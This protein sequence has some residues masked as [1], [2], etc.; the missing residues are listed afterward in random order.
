MRAR[1]NLADN[2]IRASFGLATLAILLFG[3]ALFDI[4]EKALRDQAMVQDS[5]QVL[6]KIS[7]L[8]E[9][10]ALA[11]S[12]HRGLLLTGDA[13]FREARDTALSHLKQHATAIQD[14]AASDPIQLARSQRLVTLID[15]RIAIMQNTERLRTS[16]G[17]AAAIRAFAG[18]L[19]EQANGQI[20]DLVIE[21]AEQET[22]LL[23]ARQKRE[24]EGQAT[25]RRIL[26][27]AG[28]ALVAILLPLMW[29][30][31][32]QSRDRQKAELRLRA[33]AHSLP[34][35]VYVFR[36]TPTGVGAFEFVSINAK[37]VLGIAREQVLGDPDTVR[38]LVFEEDHERITAAIVRSAGELSA[39]EVDFR[40]RKGADAF[41][42]LRSSAIPVRQADGDV[43]WHGYWFDITDT[44]DAEQALQHA[45]QRL[46]DAH[47]VA[48][49][50]DWTCDLATGAVT[51][52]SH[53][54]DML[55]RDPALG[56]LNLEEAVAIFENGAEATAD[57]FFK[58]Q[59]SGQSQAYEMK[60]RLPAGG[61]SAVHVI[62]VPTLDQTGAV[63]GMHGTIQDITVRKALE[64][65]LSLA[66]E[67]ADVANRAKSEFLA[68]MSHEIRTPLTGMLGLLEL[69]GLMPLS[70]DLRTA[71]EGVRESG[72]ALQRIIDDILDFS[73]VEAGKLEIRPEP[74]SIDEIVS[75][76]NRVYGGLAK[77]RGLEFR[78]HLD[79]RVSRSV[80]VDGLRLR[81]IL[82]NFLSNAIKFTPSGHVELRVELAERTGDLESLRFHVEDTGIGISPERQER[83]F[84]PFEQAEEDIAKRVGGT[85]L[86]LSI[87]RR[88]A[89]LMGG[90]VSIS[91]ELGKGTIL[92]LDL[93]VTVSALVPEPLMHTEEVVPGTSLPP[94]AYAAA[95]PAAGQ[96][97]EG[98]LVLVV[99]DHPINRML[100]ARQLNT[101]G[102][103]AEEVES[104]AEA[105]EQWSTGRFALVLT[106]C[107]MPEMSGYDLSRRIREME[108]ARGGGR[109]PIIACSANAIRG[110]RQDCLDAGMDEYVSKP[111]SLATLSEALGHWLP[112]PEPRVDAQAGVESPQDVQLPAGSAP[113]A[114]PSPHGLPKGGGAANRRVAEHFRRINDVDVQRLMQAIEQRDMATI[115]HLAH[116]IKGACGFIGASNLASISA[117]VEQAGRSEDGPAIDWLIDIFQ[118]EL[119]RLNAH[120][121]AA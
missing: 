73:K 34:G 18:R 75:S 35:A 104:G 82:S 23:A 26:M 1:A 77:S 3:W 62:V 44:K 21:L 87:C 93:T 80:M 60:T 15:K 119:E 76:V 102:Y 14:A 89:E 5:E 52:S 27:S 39:L 94:P 69:I 78:Q 115:A 98:P 33:I 70:A 64:E 108:S 107:H 20:N 12:D 63:I 114:G 72:I 13:Q 37:D 74:T 59:E 36:L 117:M 49:L 10:L 16:G 113:E 58:A 110:V 28:V 30:I 7:G 40:I 118:T 105:L 51:W 56:S 81:Q 45:K 4:S 92:R 11:E 66:K 47:N 85:G 79:P 54:Y 2:A 91:S 50:G 95:P 97:V 19:P 22:R 84:N 83:L 109:T 46:E 42:W 106:D 101:L 57:A 103:A 121:D 29:G 71:L 9:S 65:R 68:T 112:R 43:V 55:Q 111:T 31:T 99:D 53:V 90:K 24:R 100:M 67:A 32:R 6:Q 38:Q 120:L 61:V 116:R 25:M 96:L 48:G 88:L 17:I 86:G 41:R 8:R